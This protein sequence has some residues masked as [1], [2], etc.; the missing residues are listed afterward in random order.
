MSSN[1]ACCD[2]KVKKQATADY[3]L[4]GLGT[5]GAA[6]ARYLSEDMK[7]S[8]LVLEAG[9]DQSANPEIINPGFGNPDIFYARTADPLLNFI[10][11]QDSH[12]LNID[13][14]G[15]VYGYSDGRMWGGSS[16]HNYLFA[17]RGTPRIYNRWGVVDPRWSYNSLLP[18]M[19][20]AETFTQGS[21]YTPD[22]TQRGFAG[23]LNLTQLPTPSDP[24]FAAWAT[25]TNSRTNVL[26]PNGP[27]IFD[28]NNP[29]VPAGG[30]DVGVAGGQFYV[31]PD[32][33]TRSWSQDFLPFGTVITPSGVGVGNRKLTIVSEALATQI[34]FEGSGPTLTATGVRYLKKG[35]TFEVT[36]AKK[37]ILCGGSQA[38]PQLLQLSGIGPATLLTD[39]GIPV[40]VANDNVGAHVQNHYGPVGLI[41]GPSPNPLAFGQNGQFFMTDLTGANSPFGAAGDGIRRAEA[42]FVNSPVIPV[43]TFACLGFIDPAT[44]ISV[45]SF[46]FNDNNKLGTIRIGSTDPTVSPTML[47]AYYQDV[48]PSPT[49]DLDHAVA[50]FKAIANTSLLYNGSMPLYPPPQH[51]DSTEYPHPNTTPGIGDTILRLDA[52]SARPIGA[53][54]NSSS[55]RMATSIATG[56]VDGNLNVFGCKNL[57]CCDLS[58]APENIDANPTFAAVVIGLRLAKILGATGLP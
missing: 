25:A 40:R 37:V 50:I 5:A 16:G 30:G 18:F 3:V 9:K 34:L 24:L 33:S 35:K 42:I 39:L 19:K 8:V 27:P 7:T 1:S 21:A 58:I 49:T 48:G 46:I 12:S 38:N 10:R 15:Q 14:L 47:G 11:S 52:L 32:F 23:P 20:F 13:L 17:V 41:Q 45:L 36:A 54:H 2:N 26:G 51:F 28:Y 6:L 4:V 31:T 57:A 55:C 44:V 43:Q 53:F 29:I 56:V 22:P